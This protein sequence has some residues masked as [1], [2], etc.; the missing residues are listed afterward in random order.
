MVGGVQIPEKD[1]QLVGSPMARERESERTGELVGSPP[2]RLDPR[3]LRGWMALVSAQ[4]PA[5]AEA[6]EAG[7]G[8][9]GQGPAVCAARLVA[10]DAPIVHLAVGQRFV[11]FHVSWEGSLWG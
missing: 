3:V 8:A 4:S 10:R 5:E 1:T 2:A 6:S 7:G 11:H 9:G